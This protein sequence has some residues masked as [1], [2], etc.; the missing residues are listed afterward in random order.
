MELPQVLRE[1]RGVLVVMKPP[2]WEV[3]SVSNET[4]ALCLS[5]F[6]QQHFNRATF[7]LLHTARFGFG[8][9]HRLDVASSGLVLVGATF[10]A[11]FALQWQ[12]S[13]YEIQREYQV[14]S[15]DL[16][17]GGTP[18]LVDV[19]VSVPL[20]ATRSSHRTL[21]ME[22]TGQPAVSHF[23]S[24]AQCVAKGLADAF[25]YSMIIIRIVTG[26]RHQIRAHS[27]SMGHPT[28]CDGWYA[29][30]SVVLSQAHIYGP[31]PTR[32]WVRTPRWDGEL[33]PP[34]K[35]LEGQVF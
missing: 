1:N 34:P 31:P 27:R 15:H 28:A 30:S 2:G 32:A 10:E 29:P 12:K 17:P 21:T 20:G 11:L 6:L 24:Q 14:V 26:R 16:A 25:P 33:S 23:L 19:L 7:P 3:D 8:F 18:R 9:V 4:D 13:L 5:V 35:E 22:A